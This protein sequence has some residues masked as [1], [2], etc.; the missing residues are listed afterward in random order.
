MIEV[1]AAGASL[2]FS[3]LHVSLTAHTGGAG[4]D[5]EPVGCTVD[6]DRVVLAVGEKVAAGSVGAVVVGDTDGDAMG[7]VVGFGEGGG[8]WMRISPPMPASSSPQIPAT[9]AAAFD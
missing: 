1:F 2:T 9:H 5:G 3:Q 8:G 6:G 7:A 4:G